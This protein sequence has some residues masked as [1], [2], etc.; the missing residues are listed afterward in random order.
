MLSQEMLVLGVAVRPLQ[1]PPSLRSEGSPAPL[2]INHLAGSSEPSREH[3]MAKT[4]AVIGYRR[5]HQ[6]RC[7]VVLST[8]LS[9]EGMND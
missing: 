8:C 2:R 3:H 7:L 4:M 1:V 5:Q 6:A 9:A